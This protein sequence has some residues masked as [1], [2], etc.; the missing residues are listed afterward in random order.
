MELEKGFEMVDRVSEKFMNIIYN[1]DKNLDN[2]S[3][4]ILKSISE[5]L[6]YLFLNFSN[7]N[8]IGNILLNNEIE[9]R[10]LNNYIHIKYYN[11]YDSI[12]KDN[13]KSNIYRTLLG[14]FPVF[15]VCLEAIK[16]FNNN[17]G[18]AIFDISEVIMTDKYKERISINEYEYKVCKNI[19]VD[20]FNNIFIT[21]NIDKIFTKE[22]ININN[23]LTLSDFITINGISDTVKDIS[24]R[25]KSIINKH[26]DPNS[27]KNIDTIKNS[28]KEA[29][30]ELGYL[31]TAFRNDE[32]IPNIYFNRMIESMFLSRG[33]E[34]KYE[35][36]YG[37]NPEKT[38]IS[39]IEQIIN[40]SKP[41]FR[42]GFRNSDKSNNRGIVYFDM[43]D[44]IITDEYRQSLGDYYTYDLLKYFDDDNENKGQVFVY[45]LI[46]RF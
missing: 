15:D 14:S 13:S 11:S 23:K 3:K 42:I 43:T 36:F 8:V 4:E 19:N 40:D 17:Y 6:K 25:V 33:L 35:V 7:K 27:Y 28:L 38:G 18:S 26:Y 34:V 30:S 29:S 16:Y 24:D 32:M 22:P 1:S 9:A 45:S 20:R 31:L 37:L 46:K 5:D 41:M 2:K 21:Y 12:F 10:F 44:H 39:V